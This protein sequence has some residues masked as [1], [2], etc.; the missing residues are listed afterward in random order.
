MPYCLAV[1]A[2]V[3]RGIQWGYLKSLSEKPNSD[4]WPESKTLDAQKMFNDDPIQK[5]I[6]AVKDP[7]KAAQKIYSNTK[8]RLLSIRDRCSQILS[9]KRVDPVEVQESFLPRGLPAPE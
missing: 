8:L 3:V 2:C 7:K 9:K 5:V 4:E 1:G 6:V